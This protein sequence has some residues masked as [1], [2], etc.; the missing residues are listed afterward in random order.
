MSAAAKKGRSKT[1][2]NARARA[3]KAD[4]GPG[5]KTFE[6]FA[7]DAVREIAA[8]Q[9]EALVSYGELLTG[10]GS[11]KT[12]AGA[13]SE[14]VLKLTLKQ[15]TIYAQDAIK[16][17]GAYLRLLVSLADVIAPKQNSRPVTS[18]NATS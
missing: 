13:L 7:G 2:R 4:A 15:S 12:D 16:F 10:F 5:A 11:G 6:G 18:A 8:R 1:K 9:G 3:P 14:Q 17:G